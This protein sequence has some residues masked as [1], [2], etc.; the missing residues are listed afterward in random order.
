ML[1]L[2]G[3]NWKFDLLQATQLF[4]IEFCDRCL[5]HSSLEELG[6]LHLVLLLAA[7]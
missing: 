4:D 6:A 7:N 1:N 2:I 5:V 3:Q